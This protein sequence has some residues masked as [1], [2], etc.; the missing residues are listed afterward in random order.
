MAEIGKW[1]LAQVNMERER[2]TFSKSIISFNGL[3]KTL[4]YPKA[5]IFLLVVRKLWKFKFKNWK[6]SL[7]KRDFSIASLYFEHYFLLK[8]DKLH[9]SETDIFQWLLRTSFSCAWPFQGTQTK[10]SQQKFT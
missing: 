9:Q 2:N 4:N 7:K 5:L 1:L 3:E 8:F 10:F 6:K